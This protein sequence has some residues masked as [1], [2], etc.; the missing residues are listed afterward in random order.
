MLSW[1]VSFTLSASQHSPA[2]PMNSLLL[3][4]R[5]SKSPELLGQQVAEATRLLQAGD[6]AGAQKIYQRV[7]AAKPQHPSTWS[8]LA[9][10]AVGLGDASAAR[11]HAL[12]A[13]AMDPRHVDAGVNYGVASWHANQR[14]DAERA[15]RHA[16]VLS[17]G[18]EAPALNLMQMWHGIARYDLSADMLDAALAH[19]PVSSRLLQARADTA[20][21]RGQ[22]EG[23]RQH[24]LSTLASL[25]P[26]L[27]TSADGATPLIDAALLEADHEAMRATMAAVCDRLEGA[28][29][30]HQ[31]IG[32]V[33]LG[34]VR[35]G[36]PF[37]GDKDVDLVLPADVDRDQLVALF[38]DGFRLMRIPQVADARR[39]C[40]GWID[41]TTGIGVDLFFYETKTNGGIRQGL[42]WP[43]EL[44]FDYPEFATGTLAW[45]GRDWPVPIPLNEYL[46]SN[47]GD[48]WRQATRQVGERS[49]DKRWFDTQISCP[50]LVA[51]SVPSAI[52][53]VLLRLLGAL[54]KQQWQKALALCD[55][56]LAREGIQQVDQLRERL[57]QAE[58]G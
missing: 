40:M 1:Q 49:F 2:M 7:L 19:N 8:N 17:P 22:V 15:F 42:G 28:G 39:W 57:L 41:D 58:T 29:I 32:G 18:L 24:A 16:L 3:D 13:F 4:V 12:R 45:R 25:V 38:A 14:R 34:I 37:H 52:N 35:E 33:V 6:R 23:T 50:G 46:A 56:V 48:D 27:K 20:R 10:L 9:A 53:L 54:R 11:A 51:D 44:F 30:G 21:L 55:Q 31:L 47:Y 36:E 5:V 43:D 26:E